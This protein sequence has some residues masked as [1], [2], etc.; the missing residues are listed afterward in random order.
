MYA[1]RSYYDPVGS[2]GSPLTPRD[3]RAKEIKIASLE[4][5]VFKLSCDGTIRTA[6]IPFAGTHYVMNA[7]AAVAMGRQRKVALAQIIENLE[8]LQP[9]A[10]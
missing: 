1:I 9:V 6:S 8:K 2:V 7:L 4:Q 5:T 3:V 10:T